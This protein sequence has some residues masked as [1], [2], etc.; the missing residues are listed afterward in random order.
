MIQ[1]ITKVFLEKYGTTSSV[2][3]SPGRVNIIGEHT[4]YNEGFVLPGAIDKN[5]YVAVSKR[6]DNIIHL[7]ATDFNEDFSIN[8]EDVKKS[9]VQ[10][11]NY[12]LGVVD[13]LQKAGAVLTGFNLLVDG[14]VPIGA[15]L[16]S[17]AAVECATAFALNE[18]F[19]LGF[20]R[21]KLSYM[22]QKAE[23]VFAGVN[24]GIMDQFASM[25]GKK[26]HVI[27]LDCRSLKYEYI[28]FKLDGYK[29]V[30]LNTNVKHN[31]A[32]SE[33][34]IRRQQ[35]EEAV[36]IIKAFHPEV[37]S[38]RDVSMDMLDKYVAFEHPLIHQRCKYVI[39]ENMR[40]LAA[41]EDLKNGNIVALGN[42][43]YQ[44]HMGLSTEYEVSCK[45]LDFLVDHVKLIPGVVGA[46]MMGGGFGG[47]TINIVQED[48]IERLI[49]EVSIAYEAAM[50]LPLTSY[51]A[52]IENGT[53]C[54][55]L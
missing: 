49:K 26:D 38:L 42:K 21:I 16:S 53:S 35:C 48:A 19:E 47:C 34:N 25:L 17:S 2:F 14:D 55:E 1:K 54:C 22:A 13:Q 41:C 32:S 30:L 23:H 8:V 15:G 39:K 6:N 45:E 3:R 33:Y 31:L 46:R 44:A 4:D 50:K 36:A 9:P 28:P 29:I 7:Y 27:K 18:I 37:K 52:V 43:M 12:I 24:C 11:A 10:W 51:I 20:D 40:L 5:I